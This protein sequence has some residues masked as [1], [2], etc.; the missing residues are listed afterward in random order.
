MGARRGF[1]VAE[2]A[3]AELVE[4]I[5]E[6]ALD[7]AQWARVIRGLVELTGARCGCLFT[8]PDASG[9]VPFAVMHAMPPSLEET[10]AGA[11]RR[12]IR[13]D[14]A[15]G[16]GPGRT[17]A[18]PRD[19]ELPAEEALRAFDFYNDSLGPRDVGGILSLTVE[20]G[21]AGTMSIVSILR[22]SGTG[23]F[24]DGA[25]AFMHRCLP[26]LRHALRIQRRLSGAA[27]DAAACRE[28]LDRLGAGVILLRGDGSVAWLNREAE[29][30]L[31]SRDGIALCGSPSGAHLSFAP[32][33]LRHRL[34]PLLDGGGGSRVPASARV[35]RPSGAPALVADVTPL[36]EF[37]PGAWRERPAR[38]LVMLLDP[39]RDL[40]CGADRLMRLFGLTRAEERLALALMNHETLLDAAR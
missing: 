16:E 19:R 6:A 20:D 21:S 1:A 33:E 26:H 5:Y 40:V 34:A 29:R 32:A 11:C 31:A 37:G 2:G 14:A 13:V 36:P 7:A 35:E 24:P 10:A 17:G 15:R 28:A 18:I 3:F 23:A 39:A 8:V 38:T 22:A 12:D 27:N 9:A 25:L 4:A 30:I